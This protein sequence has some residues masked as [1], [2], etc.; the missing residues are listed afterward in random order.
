MPESE[1]AGRLFSWASRSEVYKELRPLCDRVGVKVTPHM[2]RHEF[3]SLLDELG[4]TSRDAVELSTWTT[5]KSLGRYQT[6]SADHQRRALASVNP[7]LG[8]TLG[9]KAS[10]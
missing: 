9:K 8:K 2:L 10:A 1:R 3:A 5:E 4:Y 7:N 6:P